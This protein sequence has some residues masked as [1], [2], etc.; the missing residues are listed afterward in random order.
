MK[1]KALQL[2]VFCLLTTHVQSTSNLE[3]CSKADG[4]IETKLESDK[5]ILHGLNDLINSE[6]ASQTSLAV[7]F[8]IDVAETEGVKKRVEQLRS[9][10]TEAELLTSEE[11][12]SIAKCESK[13]A[14]FQSLIQ[15]RLE[16]NL[17]KIQFLTYAEEKRLALAEGYQT[18]RKD[19]LEKN[20]LDDQIKKTRNAITEYE[21][22]ADEKIISPEE[23]TLTDEISIAT[24]LLNGLT[25]DN[26]KKYLSFLDFFK[27]KK[28]K[29]SQMSDIA[30]TV[31]TPADD[32]TKLQDELYSVKQ[33][34]RQ[35]VSELEGL[36]AKLNS[37]NI[38]EI[39]VQD[40]S[41]T[42]SKI[43]SKDL[44]EYR[45]AYLA[46]K[47][48]QLEIT[49]NITSLIEGLKKDSFLVLSKVGK[50]RATLIRE[51]DK[52]EATCIRP[53]GLSQENL[54]DFL[55][56]LRIIPLKLESGG[57]AKWFE[58]KRKFNLGL[59][60]W[61]NLSYQFF[62]LLILLFSPL[63][64]SNTFDWL[65]NKIDSLR[66]DLVSKSVMDYRQRT[67]LVI[68]LARLIPYITPLGML[69]AC[70]VAK[71]LISRTDFP[72]LTSLIFYLQ[73]FY[74]YR[75]TRIFIKMI[76]QAVFTSESVKEAKENRSRITASAQKISRL[77]FFQITILH[78]IS[79]TAR[80]ALVYTLVSN[81]VLL[82]NIAF[83]FKETRYW[84]LNITQ[85]F[86]SRFK[87]LWDKFA[88]RFNPT[89]TTLLLPFMLIACLGHDLWLIIFSYLSKLDI[90]KKVLSE[91]F[92][93]KLQ[94]SDNTTD[95]SGPPSGKYLAYFDYYLAAEE[96]IFIDRESSVISSIE[97]KANS[98]KTNQQLDDLIIIVGNRGMGKT[99]TL[100]RIHLSLSQS[101]QTVLTRVPP[102]VLT[103]NSFF[104]W[105]SDVLKTPISSTEDVLSYD[106]K[107][108]QKKI[109]LVDDIQNLFISRIGGF[110]AYETLIEVLGL[111]TKNIFW[112][113]SVNSRSWTYLK[114]VYGEE[115]FYGE[116]YHLSPWKDYE[117]QKL[118]VLRHDKTNYH[119]SYDKSIKA[120]STSDSVGQQ[121]ES[122]FFRLLWG[123]SRGNPR[124]ALMYW[125]SAISE[126]QENSIHV[127]V[128]AFIDSS[129]VGSMSDDGHFLLASLARHDS[130][131]YEE[132]LSV[133][134]VSASVVRKCL[135]EFEN[136]KL[137]WTDKDKRIRISSKAQYVVDYFLTGKNFLYE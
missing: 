129:L 23:T 36:F 103:K 8:K 40:F 127:G 117:I 102:K 69:V 21:S 132:M 1:I 18:R 16:I 101:N 62:I 76:L 35:I 28:E 80:E 29:L 98:W 22:K 128:P 74:A 89:A 66:R 67:N 137:T 64:V 27:E 25:T 112:C 122:Q 41:N 95:V 54:Q 79:D 24:A 5:Q 38:D 50:R 106:D 85:S 93:K 83:I 88:S 121:A 108:V 3:D 94:S 96:A 92:K 44:K 17:K 6:G 81:I 68:W 15:Q 90:T 111:S 84:R 34:W 133:T 58:I 130:L 30:T 9:L 65:T 63:F 12:A 134:N 114:G 43:E 109:V 107:L 33:N 47:K 2:L 13:S 75:I 120:Y 4:L 70:Q 104:L 59:D 71:N 126:P 56:E 73:I 105:L 20:K 72:E 124:S 87:G 10:S 53:R 11:F 110:E 19:I 32:P 123:Q 39:P 115:H 136:K 135:K 46:A 77:I 78:F 113:L 51:C 100:Q 116:T 91:I 45:S 55:R 7:L 60:G 42:E 125:V 86:Q 37:F 99:T 49:D 26:E 119:R 14:S 97:Q 48:R 52:I 57:A 118:I 131:S 61:L 82:I 31:T